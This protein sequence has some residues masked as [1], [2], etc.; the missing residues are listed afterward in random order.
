MH[1]HGNR[2]P[3]GIWLHPA[4]LSTQDRI[5]TLNKYLETML[6]LPDVYVVTM[7]QM[8]SFL[9]NPV[10][11]S[12]FTGFS[13]DY[14]DRYVCKNPISCYYPSAGWSM[15]SCDCVCRTDVP[16]LENPTR[17]LISP[18]PETLPPTP[19]SP[20][21]TCVCANPAPQPPGGFCLYG[22]WNPSTCQCD[23][24]GELDPMTG[25]WCADSTGSCTILKTWIPSESRYAT[26]P[27]N[28]G[29]FRDC[30]EDTSSTSGDGDD[31][32]A[33]QIAPLS[34][35]T[36]PSQSAKWLILAGILLVVLTLVGLLYAR[37]YRRKQS[38]NQE[39]Q[40]IVL[41]SIESNYVHLDSTKN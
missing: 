23:C 9:K 1:Y 34:Q 35:D 18:C 31:G 20:P 38:L 8:L 22:T 28:P 4:W 16:T 29:Y 27:F 2:A 41:T 36:N 6:S 32:T 13:C 12:S 21:M 37:Y 26:C 14:S 11:V 30:T 10:P 15:D 3:F 5:S 19:P 40:S 39:A 33:N 7:S 25:G 17:P 24:I